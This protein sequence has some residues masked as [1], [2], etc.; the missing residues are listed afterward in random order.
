MTTPIRWEYSLIREVTK[1]RRGRPALKITFREQIS[2]TLSQYPY[3][4]TAGTIQKVLAQTGAPRVSWGTIRKYLEELA[5]EGLVVRQS[6]ST[7]RKQRPLI[8]YS[9]CGCRPDLR[10]KMAKHISIHASKVENHNINR[11]YWTR[12]NALKEFWRLRHIVRTFATR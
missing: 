2:N 9:M 1:T 12:I 5:A 3:P 6:F 4:V 11:S 8:L 10:G 7:E